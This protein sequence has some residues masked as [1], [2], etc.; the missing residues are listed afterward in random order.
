MR[1][2]FGT[3]ARLLFVGEGEMSVLVPSQ[4]NCLTVSR[5]TR[6]PSANLSVPDHSWNCLGWD[7]IALRGL[8]Y[9]IS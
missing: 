4:L 7:A 9:I 8:R 3:F 2:P 1:D 6:K 5:L